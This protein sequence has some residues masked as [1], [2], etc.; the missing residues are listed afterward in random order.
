MIVAASLAVFFLCG[1]MLKKDGEVSRARLVVPVVDSDKKADESDIS[2]FEETA[3]T[4]FI[5]LLSDETLLSVVT[6]DIDGD[7]FDDQINVVK[8][9]RSPYLSLVCALYEPS[10][11]EYV[12]KTVIDTN[13]SQIRTFS[14]T[15]IDVIG[16]HKNSLIYQGVRDNGFSVLKIYNGGRDKNNEF[17][18][19]VIGDFESDGTIFIQQEERNEAYE[20]GRTKGEPFPVW[21]Y[22]SG[23]S[24]DSASLD[25]IQTMF[26]WNESEQSYVEAKKITVAGKRLAAKELAR[27]QD[28]TVETFSKFLDGLWY[29]TDVSGSMRYLFF[30]YQN[31]EIIFQFE[32]SEEVYSWLDSKLRRNGMYFSSVNKSIGNLHRRFDISL[33]GIDE[34]R[35]RL[36]DDVRMIIGESTLWDGN[37]KKLTS[38]KIAKPGSSPSKDAVQTLIETGAWATGDG[39]YYFFEKDRYSVDG[40][41]VSDFGMFLETEV[42]GTTLLQ[43]RSESEKKFFSGFYSVEYGKRTVRKTDRRGRTVEETADDKETVV[44]HA[45][46]VRPD[47]FF[48]T[49]AR[50][51]VLK[52]TEVRN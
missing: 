19:D 50:P 39:N 42:S 24:E 41:N 35:I 13:V 36:Q 1:E 48:Q 14:C 34:I 26:V 32:D 31:Q 51:L 44:M 12:R 17:V 27:I 9:S 15:S 16:N 37:Y 2:D 47:G 52:K 30:D 7:G 25:Q 43:F 46:L 49:E 4:S 5:E 20:L 33:V 28:G 6:M 38:T 11:T 18:L 10:E 22:S 29:K 23:A 8:S 3:A 40:D 45:V 21:V